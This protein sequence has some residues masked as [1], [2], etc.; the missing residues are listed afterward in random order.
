MTLKEVRVRFDPRPN[1]EHPWIEITVQ[2]GQYFSEITYRLP[3]YEVRGDLSSVLSS[4]Q[5][6][7]Q[8]LVRSELRG[9]AGT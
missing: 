3:F 5:A 7:T 9:S 4:L 1:G 6:A 8:H 2:L